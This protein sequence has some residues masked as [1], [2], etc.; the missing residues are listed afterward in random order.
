MKTQPLRT[1]QVQLPSGPLLATIKAG[2]LPAEGGGEIAR[3]R[4]MFPDMVG[5]A[6]LDDGKV[7]ALG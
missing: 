1:Y 7:L 4:I 5:A 3:L 6:L 2:Y